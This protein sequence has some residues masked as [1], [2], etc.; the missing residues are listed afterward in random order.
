MKRYVAGNSPIVKRL[1]EAGIIPWE[2]TKFSLTAK[3]DEVIRMTLECNVTEEQFR[4][5]AD[6]L[7]ENPEEAKQ[8][9]RTTVLKLPRTGETLSI[10]LESKGPSDES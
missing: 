4:Q 8:I 3:Y 9:V 2:C 7:I 1:I 6:A 10:D 5:I